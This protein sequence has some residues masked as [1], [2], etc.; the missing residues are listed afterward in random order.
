MANLQKTRAVFGFTSP[1]SIE[2]AIP[3]IELLI[4]NFSG[5]P[6]DGNTQLDFFESLKKSGFY[7]SNKITKNPRLAAR[8]RI[9][10]APKALGFVG[11]KPT[12]SIT[13]A[14]EML[15]SRKRSHEVFARQLL[16]F[17]L[18]SPY[19]PIPVNRNFNVRPYLELLRF[20]REMDGV[21]KSEVAIFFLQLTNYTKF[22]EVVN[23][24]KKHREDAKAWKGNRKAFIQEVFNREL[25]KVY[26]EEIA[27]EDF[28]TRE[29]SDTSLK[30]FLKTKRSNHI[31]YADAFIRYLR[32]TQLVTFAK[33][34]Y[35]VIIAP[36]RV[37]EVEF[38]LKTVDRK[39]KDL[40][41]AE[42]ERYL[43]N[44]FS[45]KLLTDDRSYL[46][47]RLNE[48]G[49]SFSPTVDSEH[50]KDLIE[51]EEER[52]LGE[53]IEKTE[54]SL[55]DYREYGDIIN[56]FKQIKEKEVPDPPLYLE[57]N[58][59]R[60]LVMLNYANDVRGN[61]RIDFDG[62]PL[63]CA[64]GGMA[65]IEAEY[66]GFNMII[67]VTTSTGS[68]QYEMEGESVPRHLGKAQ[69][70]SSNPV[71]CLFIA[72][73][74]NENALAHFFNL[75]RFNTKAYGGKTRIVPMSLEQ[76]VTFINVAKESGFKDARQLKNFLDHLVEVNQVADDEAVWQEEIDSSIATWVG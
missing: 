36:F 45:V 29:S 71:Y 22:D 52:L 28:K 41:L 8:D 7:D 23:A 66:D 19:H 32:A 10:R 48:L 53:A 20:V 14:G 73:K 17:Q 24:L 39:A 13:A 59:W 72:P 34:N 1:R 76:F 43:F 11:L 70:S 30:K 63:S 4:E 35:R 49:L 15:L 44:P 25:T 58:V 50:M 31:D 62:V 47:A 37:K 18:P 65:D 27:K 64:Q 51:E 33:G 55:K 6:W 12:I 26:E 9:T 60:S 75:N 69:L 40:K 21:S 56:V 38:I 68:K 57:W 16:K 42:Y 67:E 2:K 5:K 54:R 74:V 61:F 3:E 46:E